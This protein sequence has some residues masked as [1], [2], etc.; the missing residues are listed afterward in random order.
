MR[1]LGRIAALAAAAA[2]LP[3]QDD[4]V[5]G[6]TLFI[7]HGCAHCH[8]EGYEG[9]LTLQSPRGPDLRRAGTRLHPGWTE[10]W[11]RDPEGVH[12]QARMPALLPAGDAGET[13]ARDLAAYLATLGGAFE[14]R[15]VP[16]HNDSGT[17]LFATRGCIACHRRPGDATDDRH[18]L[19]DL[20]AK[21]SPHALADYLTNPL[22]VHPRGLMPDMALSRSD[23][24][25]LA[26]MLCTEPRAPA[27]A[28]GDAERG[29]Q[30]AR[31]YRCA[32]CHELP[33]AE[34]DD[35]G[36][37]PGP[38]PAPPP[39][40]GE[41][42]GR[43]GGCL[44]ESPA[45]G[46]PRYRLSAGD[47]TALSTFLA[48]PLARE[49]RAA[50]LERRMTQLRCLS[51]H[52]KD[53]IG[54][55]PAGVLGEYH[56]AVDADARDHIDPP[57]LTAI[58]QRL[59][60]GWVDAVLTDR[61]RA[62]PYMA[63]RMPHYSPELTRDLA[64]LLVPGAPPPSARDDRVED[65]EHGRTL[66]GT[67]GFACIICH[68]FAGRPANGTRAPDLTLVHR[69]LQP[70]WLRQWLTSPMEVQPGTRMPSYFAGGRS[71]APHVLDG[72]VDAQLNALVAYLSQGDR[73]RPPLGLAPPADVVLEPADRLLLWRTIL[74]DLPPRS[75]AL[76]FPAGLSVAIDVATPR[77]GYAWEGGFLD[78]RAKW[79]GRGNGPA[80]LVGEI[81][82]RGAADGMLRRDGA[83]LDARFAGYR[84][85]DDHAVLRFGVDG[86]E[87]SLRVDAVQC[88]SAN[89]LHLQVSWSGPQ[90]L[91]VALADAHPGA[92]VH[93]S[94]ER[95]L[96]RLRG[97]SDDTLGYA[98]AATLTTEPT[99]TL[100]VDARGTAAAVLWFPTAGS[101]DALQHCLDWR[102]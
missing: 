102:P 74:P 83:V 32:A 6:R 21:T 55:M 27:E 19:G 89:G 43:S 77:L 63:L 40:L 8:S 42:A 41:L 75:L 93:R 54:G 52:A 15:R 86:G 47:R 94:A 79:T 85:A 88:A 26:A 96:V 57:A 46:L 84:L 72:N 95:V 66:V 56:A 91:A 50:V 90:P 18:L 71:A 65:L 82:L 81:L 2:G 73:M 13:E 76:G 80:A 4:L 20:A 87:L 36:E 23:A 30:L 28:N 5:R 17:A 59:R 14:Y 62:R 7:N 29:R 1:R 22:A 39:P 45:P 98:S 9:P 53:D 25:A 99:V 48:A 11:L 58:D 68:D 16:S 100:P 49:A 67:G 44:D 24:E 92:Q 70:E 78:M 64:E 34:A 12:A 97:A 33:A 31:S 61:A 3:A 51:C 101:A 10:Q 37:G 69:R 60:L 35:D 38:T